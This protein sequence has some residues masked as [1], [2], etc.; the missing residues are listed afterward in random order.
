M[1][2]TK[3]SVNLYP[4]ARQVSLTSSTTFTHQRSS[5]DLTEEVECRL[6]CGEEG[7]G[8]GLAP[9]GWPPWCGGRSPFSQAKVKACSWIISGFI[10]ESLRGKDF[11]ECR[12]LC[13]GP[14]G[15]GAMFWR[16]A[17]LARVSSGIRPLPHASRGRGPPNAAVL[18]SQWLSSEFY[19]G[20]AIGNLSH[21][22][23]GTI[24]NCSRG[25]MALSLYN[26]SSKITA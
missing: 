8:R 12:G 19:R 13:C 26:M 1:V 18:D 24:R 4:S 25:G 6:P 10:S 23:I 22:Q 3:L 5:T 9:R 21:Y 15:R 16:L 7:C 14:E 20:L 2:Y 11:W 17:R